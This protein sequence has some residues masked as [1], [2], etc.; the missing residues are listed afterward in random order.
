MT[1]AVTR[2]PHAVP[3]PVPP[4]GVRP[5]AGALLVGVVVVAGGVRGPGPLGAGVV[6]LQLCTLSGWHQ[7]LRVPGALGGSLVAIAA[8][9]G[10]VL[11][12]EV[13]AGPSPVEDVGRLAPVLGLAL[14]ACFGHQAIRRP[15]RPQLLASLSATASLVVAVVLTALWVAV[16][17]G[18]GGLDVVLVGAVAAVVAAVAAA[19]VPR[20]GWPV[21]V[22]AGAGAGLV[23]GAASGLDLAP[24]GV[25]LLAAG[26]AGPAVVAA[27]LRAATGRAA[28][29]A[30]AT[31]AALPCALAAL[32]LW[33][34]ARILLGS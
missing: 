4:S 6:L 22:L 31:L 27:H 5:A 30:P 11:A 3:G 18:P 20:G 17:R 7:L 16:L 10:A 19:V 12:L 24:P 23:T 15:P 9:L 34:L 2:S 13:R 25:V 26:A 8:G 32:P 1:D 28:R 21:S 29:S 14:V 33:V